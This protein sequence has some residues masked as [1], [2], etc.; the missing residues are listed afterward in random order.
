MR[1]YDIR[2]G[3]KIEW[4]RRLTQ[5]IICTL[6]HCVNLLAHS[7]F[8]PFLI[9][10]LLIP[11]TLFFSYFLFSVHISFYTYHSSDLLSFNL[12]FIGNTHLPP[13]SSKRSLYGSPEE[14]SLRRDLSI[15]SL[16]FNIHTRQL[17]DHCHSGLNDL[18]N[19]TF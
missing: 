12:C 17:E 10:S 8:S 1:R 16:F 9:S 15:N 7:I 6:F 13:S 14:D 19:G 2:K 3:E 5:W 4:A 18:M 11:F